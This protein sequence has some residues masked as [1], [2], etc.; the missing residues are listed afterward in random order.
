MF[1]SGYRLP[2]GERT[3][4]ATDCYRFV[5]TRPEVDVCMA[6]PADASQMEQAIEAL[7]RGPM[8]DNEIAWMRRIGRA[9][10]GNNGRAP[11]LIVG[12]SF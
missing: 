8:T 12:A 10:S 6:G 1:S 11:P 9:V 5:L 7:R 4:T 3:P 2:K